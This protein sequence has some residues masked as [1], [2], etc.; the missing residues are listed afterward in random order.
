MVIFKCLFKSLQVVK[1]ALN[2]IF[3]L[4]KKRIFPLQFCIFLHIKKSC[5]SEHLPPPDSFLHCLYT[6]N[7]PTPISLNLSLS[8]SFS[9]STDFTIF[10]VCSPTSDF[11][12][13]VQNFTMV[14][15]SYLTS[16][17]CVYACVSFLD[18]KFL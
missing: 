14:S 10:H 1:V 15:S 8:E 12:Q 17:V 16:A 6:H 3:Y 4:K 2:N 13:A 9:Y 7:P 18:S 5:K 11:L